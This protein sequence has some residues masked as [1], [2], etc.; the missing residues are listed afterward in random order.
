[1]KAVSRSAAGDKEVKGKGRRQSS[2]KH[3]KIRIVARRK[4]SGKI[5]GLRQICLVNTVCHSDS[6]ALVLLG[7]RRD[8]R[9][10]TCIQP[11]LPKE[12]LGITN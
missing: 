10:M 5:L 12:H 3:M 11:L 9:S 7:L 8:L 4:V 1:M 6:D 2:N